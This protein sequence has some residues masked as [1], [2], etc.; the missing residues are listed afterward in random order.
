MTGLPGHEFTQFLLQESL[1][2][3]AEHLIPFGVLLT[4]VDQLEHFRELHGQGA[5][6]AVLR[7]VGQTLRSTLRPSDYLGR[8]TA[9]QF[10]VIVPSCSRALTEKVGNRLRRIASFSE[11]LWWGDLLSVTVSA[12]GTAVRLGDSV[13]SILERVAASLEQ[14]LAE[15]GDRVTVCSE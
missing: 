1:T 14:S 10:L 2:F 6:D 12:G 5:V 11:I 7:A 8:W 3:F 9:D 15:G 4:Q 13:E